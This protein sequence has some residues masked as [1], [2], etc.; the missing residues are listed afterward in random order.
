[1]TRFGIA[2]GLKKKSKGNLESI[3]NWKKV[4][5]SANE[6]EESGNATCQKV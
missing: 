2:Q 5:E 6:L 3:M 4:E 1:M